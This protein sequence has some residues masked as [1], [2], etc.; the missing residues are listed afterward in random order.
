MRVFYFTLTKAYA[1]VCA[2]M[3]TLV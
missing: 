1:Y 2:C 3:F